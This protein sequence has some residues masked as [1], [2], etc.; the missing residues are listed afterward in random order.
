MEL[1]WYEGSREPMISSQ[2]IP[3]VSPLPGQCR[4]IRVLTLYRALTLGPQPSGKSQIA[5]GREQRRK[6]DSLYA[7]PVV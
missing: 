1:H 4:L 7:L 6:N 3:P 2:R 5:N